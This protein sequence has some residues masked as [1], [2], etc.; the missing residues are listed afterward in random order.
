MLNRIFHLFFGH[1]FRVLL[2]LAFGYFSLPISAETLRFD[3]DFDGLFDNREFKGDMKPQTIDGMRLTPQIGIE[4]QNSCLMFGVSKVWEF[5]TFNKTAPEAIIYFNYNNE[6]ISTYFG[7][8][9][10]NVLQKQLPD[11]FLYDSIAFFDNRIEGII[12]QYESPSF[13]TEVYCNWFSKQSTTRREAFRIVSDGHIGKEFISGGWFLALTHYAK[14]STGNYHIY[15][16]CSFNPYIE[17]NLDRFLPYSYHL[18]VN[19]G[20]MSSFIRSR[21]E[22]SWH[23]PFGFL[24][25]IDASWKFINLRN[26]T[27]AGKAQ[28]EFLHDPM[29]GVEFHRS[30]PF[31]NHSFYNRTDM[32]ITWKMNDYS[33]AS[34][35]WSLHVT[36]NTELHNQQLIKVKFYFCNRKAINISPLLK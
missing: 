36:P 3:L 13:S 1:L 10:R 31:Y 14:P 12:L 26:T 6:K 24:G 16:K 34:F 5:G 4:S 9:P 32:G 25:S 2:L 20:L 29:A 30:D 18:N 15:E 33:E 19:A 22:D 8:M 28:Q 23:S 21:I 11:A 7:A 17:F 35:T 27:Y